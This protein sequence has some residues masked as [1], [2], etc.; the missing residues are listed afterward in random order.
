MR[1]KQLL[2]LLIAAYWVAAI[3]ILVQFEV[4]RFVNYESVV[5][6]LIL[7]AT[8]V[9]SIVN[10]S[11][12]SL[13]L[14]FMIADLVF[15][16][17][18][19]GTVKLG[20]LSD[21]GSQM[22]MFENYSWA[23]VDE[24]NAWLRQGALSTICFSMGIYYIDRSIGRKVSNRLVEK[25]GATID[26][27]M[28]H[29]FV[30]LLVILIYGISVFS[31]IGYGAISG[32][33]SDGVATL[34][35][36]LTAEPVVLVSLAML[37]F[38][39]SVLSRRERAMFVLLLIFYMAFRLA[40]GNRSFF[41]QM[42]T[43]CIVFL[44][45][46]RGNFFVPKRVL[47]GILIFTLLNISLYPVALGLKN[48]IKSKGAIEEGGLLSL[49]ENVSVVDY[50][51]TFFSEPEGAIEIVDRLSDM[52]APLRIINDA[53]AISTD[54]HFSFLRVIKRA[55]N[56][57][58]PGDVFDDV[59]GT[60]QVWHATFFGQDA[61]YGGEELGIYGVYYIHFGYIG[62]L[63]ALV[64]AGFV[65]AYL[66]VRVLLMRISYRPILLAY[67][68]NSIYIFIHNPMLEVWF[69]VSVYRSVFT[70]L[71]LAGALALMGHV[72]RLFRMRPYY[73]GG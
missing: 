38:K 26:I 35:G 68:L 15:M 6:L 31:R 22:W 39:W 12:V 20:L 24:V 43:I 57:M 72:A 13:P 21:F 63:I 5:Y 64:V 33:E 1:F 7:S 18:L 55:I 62:S 67:I 19:L 42:L 65:G 27:R 14:F 36:I 71:L 37:A 61:I 9:F 48:A 52:G 44:S 46:C 3:L 66:W 73:S 34:Y 70:L 51:R 23:G 53:G 11:R 30:L 32:I 45:Y 17:Y 60:Q 56:D 58:V 59:I 50:T 69:V 4:S 40:S 49:L 41:I 29:L 8:I 25:D 16:K 28:N 47:A 10:S 2:L 54:E